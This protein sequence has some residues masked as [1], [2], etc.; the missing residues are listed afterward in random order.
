M[1]CYRDSFRALVIHLVR[2]HGADVTFLST[3][4]GAPGYHDDSQIAAV[5]AAALPE[6]VRSRVH[7]DSNF[8]T[9]GQL[10]DLL[11]G[12]DFVVSTRMHLAILALGVGTP[13]LPIAYE[14]KTTEL[15]RSL[16]YP[17]PP[18]RIEEFSP[19]KLIGSVERFVQCYNEHA[20]EINEAV[21]RF[22]REAWEVS[23]VLRTSP[24]L[25]VTNNTESA[26]T[27]ETSLG[28]EQ[29]CPTR[30]ASHR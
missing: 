7:V 21:A 24:P 10:A 2:V 8:H 16:E 29:N 23:D 6:E 18:L 9:P 25:S 14:F 13:V 28:V 20:R 19:E 30:S 11:R 17:E 3:C 15:C 1:A 4:Q 12:F 27:T 26:S 5:I 22:R